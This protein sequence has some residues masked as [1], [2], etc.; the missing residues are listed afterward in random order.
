MLCWPPAPVVVAYAWVYVLPSVDNWMVNALAYAFSQLIAIRLIEVVAPRSTWNHWL[1]ANALDQRVPLLPSTAAE[2]GVPAH[3]TDEAVTG[4]PCDTI[5]SG[6]AAGGMGG[7]G[8]AGGRP[9]GAGGRGR[10]GGGA[11]R[12]P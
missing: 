12:G 9:G 1:A 6:G 8:E 4:L 2:A 10:G 5:V 11:R 3:S 7:A